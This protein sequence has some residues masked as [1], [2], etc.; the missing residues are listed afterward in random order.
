V[1]LLVKC[2]NCGPREAT[3]FVFGGEV[4]RRPSGRP[5]S[6][7]E[8]SAYLYFRDNPAGPQREW[9]FHDAGCG[10]WLIATR[11]TLGGAVAATEPA[12]GG[13]GRAAT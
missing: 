9:W 3:E 12:G 13:G 5:P 8:L 10:R 1:T 7:R 4:T 2:P 11:D 6:R